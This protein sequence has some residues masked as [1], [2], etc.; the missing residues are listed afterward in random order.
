MTVSGP[1]EMG[2]SPIVADQTEALIA[3]ARRAAEHAYI[4]YSGFRTGAA[5]LTEDGAIH[6]GALVENLVFGAAM[7]AECVALFSSVASGPAHPTHL[8]LVAP[9]TAGTLTFPCGPCLQVAVELGGPDL[10]VTAV[11]LDGDG[12]SQTRTVDEL[13]PGIPRRRGRPS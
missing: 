9:D 8:A 4:P 10:P 5:V 2:S 6:V 12:A 7:C 13:A 3:A 11:P 1:G